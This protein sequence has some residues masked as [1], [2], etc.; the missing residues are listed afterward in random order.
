MHHPWRRFRDQ[1]G[2][3]ALATT[4]LPGSLHAVTDGRTVWMHEPLTQAERRVA[5]CHETIH[6]EA[7]EGCRQ[8]PGRER[9]HNREV[10]RRLID[11]DELAAAMAWTDQIDELAADLWVTPLIARA[12]ID[13]LWPA[14]VAIISEL[15]ADLRT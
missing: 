2:H 14:E 13:M 7:G 9:Q 6:L 5:I 12:R 11:F 15:I 8:S 4:P 10:A 1:W 3:V